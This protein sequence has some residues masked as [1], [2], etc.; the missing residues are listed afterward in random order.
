MDDVSTQDNAE[1]QDVLTTLEC[2]GAD[3]SR[4]DFKELVG[5][6]SQALDDQLAD[7]QCDGLLERLSQDPCDVLALE[8]LVIVG[9][10][11]P[12]VV[13]NRRIPVQQE[14]RRLAVLLEKS[15]D[16]ERAQAVLESL[17]ARTP[18]DRGVERELS[19]LMRRNGNLARLVER[20][21]A[22]AD[23]CVREGR[24]D[25]AV[26]WLREVLMLDPQRRDV[27]RM[28]RDLNYAD[29]E[30]RGAWR[31]GLKATVVSLVCL[32]GLSGVVWRENSLDRAF[33]SIPPAQAGDLGAMQARLSALDQLVAESPL[34][35]GLFRVSRERASLREQV[36]RLRAERAEQ[37][38]KE[39]QAREL[40]VTL[41]ESQYSLARLAA[42]RY[43]FDQMQEHLE[44][45]LAYGPEDWSERAQIERELAALAE[46]RQKRAQASKGEQ[47]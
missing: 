5:K 35:M 7:E 29:L 37:E 42:Q 6:A 18:S 27:A 43:E 28:I 12:E 31:K 45:A 40:A 36:E 4:P 3:G 13:A 8:A 9:L 11:R 26:R 47:R 10:A 17:L 14:G 32:S 16:S 25:E 38:A 19:S 21:L 33:A 39:R 30:R 24:R 2:V 20:Y 22:R 1:A 41:A 23:E 15:G 44:A 34:W 46:H